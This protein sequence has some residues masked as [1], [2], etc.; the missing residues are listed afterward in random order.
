MMTLKFVTPT[1]CSEI[2][3]CDSVHLIMAS[4]T[5]GKGGGSIGIRTGFE[6]AMIVLDSGNVDAFLSGNK[7]FSK[8]SDGG[9]ATVNDDVI[10]VI[11]K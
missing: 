5:D 6:K 4:G 3:E 9:F 7:V 8:H 1:G 11:S 2:V 10:V